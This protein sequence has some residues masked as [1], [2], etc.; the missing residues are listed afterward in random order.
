MIADLL[1]NIM[2]PMLLAVVRNS[3]HREHECLKIG[4]L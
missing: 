1:N 4:N 2:N 3:E